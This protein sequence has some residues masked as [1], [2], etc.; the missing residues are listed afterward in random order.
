MACKKCKIKPVFKLLSGEQLCK[1][2]FIKYFERKVRKTIR[3][4]NLLGKETDIAVAVSG[5]KDSLTTLYLLN[6][7]ATKHIKLNITAI[8]INEGIKGYRSQTIKDAKRLCKRLGIKL[9]I[10]SFKKEFGLTLDEMVKKTGIAACT[11]CG[12]FRRY[13]LNKTARKLNCKLLATG[14]NLDDESQAIIMNQFRRNIETSARL[15]P[16]TGI[17]KHE[18]FIPRIKPLYFMSEKETAA[19]AFLKGF[20]TKFIECPYVQKSYRSK[21]RDML[22]NFAEHHPGIKHNI[23]ASF[24]ELLPLLRKDYKVGKINACKECNEP[25]S[26]TICK[27]CKL[28][29]KL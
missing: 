29:S 4:H 11:L 26:G 12:V 16:R 9:H 28:K 22:N 20:V 21:I 19:Y 23:V 18:M 3:T 6:Q 8:C 1:S 10:V 15:G 25:C 14:H 27:A 7:I 13:L 5:G 24:L 2:C 17:M